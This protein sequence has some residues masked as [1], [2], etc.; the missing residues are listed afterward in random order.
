MAGLALIS[1]QQRCGVDGRPFPNA[2]A[3]FY[4]AETLTPIT[5]YR[6]YSLGSPHP[7]PVVAD[8][9][10][11]FPA[12]FIDE[13]EEFYRMRITTA[14]GVTLTDLVTLPV[15]G[16]SGGGGGSEVPVDP[17][18][19]FK[20]GYP[21]WL[22]KT[23]TLAGFVRMNRRTIGAAGSG[24]SERANADTEALYTFLY[25]N[26]P[27]SICPV[28]GGRGSNA[29][30]DFA[31]LKP[32]TNLDMRNKGPF[33]L[34][35]MGNSAAGG[36]SGITF[37]QGNATTAGATGGDALEILTEA[38]LPSL[39]KTLN[40]TDPG[41][42]HTFQQRS[43]SGSGILQTGGGNFAGGTSTQTTSTATTGITGSVSFGG[44]QAHNN[45]P[46]FMLGTWY[47]KL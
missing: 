8:A 16:P 34:D 11:V 12:I 17:D 28:I 14:S 24:A 22:P 23:G 36:F 10:G 40:L 9:Y 32:I 5:T 43:T 30:A 26:F 18:A 15:I 1:M 42:P 3:Y 4:E 39:T 31:A 2:R 25:Q 29:A 37:D 21:L 19:L 38:Q 35:D 46:P 13:A 41:H 6:D 44:G 7:S 20:T 47:I 27:D 33:G 45:M